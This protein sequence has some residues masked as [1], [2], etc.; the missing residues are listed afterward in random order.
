MRQRFRLLH[1]TVANVY[2][3]EHVSEEIA[4]RAAVD[5]PARGIL[6]WDGPMSSWRKYELASIAMTIP[7]FYLA[8]QSAH[9]GWRFAYALAAL[10]SAI[11]L[12][13][14]R[15]ARRAATPLRIWLARRQLGIW[16]LSGLLLCALLPSGDAL[17]LMLVRLG[18]AVL[19][20][21]RAGESLK[22]WF[23]RSDLPRLVMLTMAVF[24]LCG[25]G[26]WWLEPHVHTFG[27]GVW[28]AFTTAATVGYG[29]I[30]PSTPAAKVFA[31]FVVML[32]VSILSLV[33]ASIT[34]LWVQSGER[35]MEN[36]LL[37]HLHRE[38]KLMRE[39][40]ESLKPRAD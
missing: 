25:L 16:L 5:I 34:A 15:S 31:V 30:V 4:D 21:L 39:T 18:T 20:V 14:E 19:V 13:K 1:L 8:L 6:S 7:A 10:A 38:L 40:L 2:P 32:G 29:D 17:D 27:D 3:A 35:Q 36:D 12:W 24:G 9:L 23:W 33:T 26:F 11:V 28:L 22:P 37:E